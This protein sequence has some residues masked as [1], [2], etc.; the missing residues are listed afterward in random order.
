MRL[1]FN[2]LWVED[3]RDRVKAQHDRIA[4]TIRKEGFKLNAQ[5]ASTVA[6][7]KKFISDDIY[8]DHVDLIVMDYDLGPGPKGDKGIVDLR[9][10][11]P[12]KE[13]IF[14]SAQAADLLGLLHAAKVDGVYVSTREDLTTNVD[15]VFQMLVKK[16]IDI[17]H[18]RGIVM[19]ATSEID[20]LINDCLV[21]YFNACDEGSRA[22]ILAAIAAR[23]GEI[24]KRF[25]SELEKLGAIKHV[26]EIAPLH[27]TYTS[28]DRLKLLRKVLDMLNQHK[29]KKEQLV[30]YG[31]KVVP[32]RN[33]MAH[34]RVEVNG[35]SRK[36]FDREKKEL[37]VEHMRELRVAILES[38]ELFESIHNALQKG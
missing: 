38:R 32:R 16:V 34:V 13:I 15:G 22:K 35:F 27:A 19:G 30:S 26:S 21:G 29:D 17:E 3:Q 18:S 31:E 12:Y 28:A 11:L 10:T 24:K 37:T 20:H 6:D 5:F 23:V 8:A 4:T 1:D 36:L 7:A 9:Q 25:E 33:D 14:Y 2:L